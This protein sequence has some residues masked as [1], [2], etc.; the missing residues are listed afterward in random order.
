[1][2]EA[3]SNIKVRRGSFRYMSLVTD[4]VECVLL[5]SGQAQFPMPIDYDQFLRI[6]F[7][8]QP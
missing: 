8:F 5:S 6:R 1:V 4:V 2:I 7:A 3:D